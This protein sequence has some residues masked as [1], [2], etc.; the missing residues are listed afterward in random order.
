MGY[1]C[2]PFVINTTEYGTPQKRERVFFIGVRNNAD[3]EEAM[4]SNILSQRRK[5]PTI[6]DLF[7]D[8][9]PAGAERNPRTCNAKITFAVRPVMRHVGFK[10]FQMIIFSVVPRPW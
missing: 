2:I 8:L 7:S 6:R 9:G 3:F 10:P 1:G 4:W 5:A